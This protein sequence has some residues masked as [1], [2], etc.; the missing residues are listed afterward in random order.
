LKPPLNDG[1]TTLNISIIDISISYDNS[2]EFFFP[3]N[4]YKFEKK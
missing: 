2:I 1:E 4:H 3:K